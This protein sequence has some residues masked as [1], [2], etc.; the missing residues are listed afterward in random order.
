M[1]MTSTTNLIWLQSDIKTHF[2]GEYG[3]KIH[4]M[5]PI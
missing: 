2:K 1:V 3:S 5:E 4:E